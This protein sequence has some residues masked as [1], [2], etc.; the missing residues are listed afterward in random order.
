[1]RVR[2]RVEEA[3]LLAGLDCRIDPTDPGVVRLW[4]DEPAE[5]LRHQQKRPTGRCELCDAAPARIAEHAA[6]TPEKFCPAKAAQRLVGLVVIRDEHVTYAEVGTHRFGSL[7]R[8]SITALDVLDAVRTL[9][10]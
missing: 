5:M 8:S 3:A 2:A 7:G 6:A 10:A 1:M 9:G 4:A